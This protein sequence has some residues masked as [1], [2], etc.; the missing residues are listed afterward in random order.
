[1][2]LDDVITKDL[3]RIGLPKRPRGRKPDLGVK[4]GQLKAL[5]IRALAFLLLAIVGAFGLLVI[6]HYKSTV[7]LLIVLVYFGL[8]AFLAYKLFSLTYVGWLYTLL[9]SAAGILM[10]VLALVSRGFSNPT[11]AA[12][13]LAVIIISLCS[14]A[15]LWWAKDL[16]GIKSY[17]EIFVPYV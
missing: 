8:G 1:M 12:G 11:L 6:S 9:L 4:H 17:R 10:P 3:E 5:A 14:A 13:A 16:F 2:D 7:M 15:L